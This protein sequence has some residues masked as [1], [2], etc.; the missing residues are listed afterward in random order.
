MWTHRTGCTFSRSFSRPWVARP[1]GAT[2]IATF[3][4]L[5]TEHAQR[6]PRLMV[7][8]S[9][10]EA[11]ER[12]RPP[13]RRRRGACDR[14]PGRHGAG[15]REQFG[16]PATGFQ[17]DQQQLVDMN[18]AVNRGTLLALHLG[19][20][21]VCRPADAATHKHRQAR[22]HPSGASGSAYDARAVG[23]QR[24]HARASRHAPHGL[25]PAVV[26]GGGQSPVTPAV[27]I[28]GDK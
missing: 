21:Y 26:T 10:A 22:Q 5:S 8:R 17:V 11:R 9:A 13:C 16:R 3:Q 2:E 7:A 28:M 23:R 12:R 25:A 15:K 4:T 14:R 19:R 18:I 27:H 6:I 24:H 20:M 1:A